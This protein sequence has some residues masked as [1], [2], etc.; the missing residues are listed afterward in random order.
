LKVTGSVTEKY[1]RRGRGFVVVATVT[2]DEHG[3][4]LVD[5]KTTFLP[6]EA[7]GPVRSEADRTGSSSTEAVGERPLEPQMADGYWMP[8]SLGPLIRRLTLRRMQE[9]ER[10]SEFIVNRP[11]RE[12]I[13]ANPDLAKQ[14]GQT[15]PVAS[16]M[17]SVA[18][19]NHLLRRAFGESWTTSGHLAVK[20]VRPLH[21]GDSLS[22]RAVVTGALEA[23]SGPRLQ[24]DIWCEDAEG[25]QS[26]VGTAD[27]AIAAPPVREFSHWSSRR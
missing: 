24:L 12:S 1:I 11:Q 8:S 10:C 22:A 13:H 16:G 20:H 18:H 14:A 19:L 6:L 23:P 3:R 17:H 5:S 4:H 7:G 15:A 9:F 2:V 26:T 25:H 27:L 21:A